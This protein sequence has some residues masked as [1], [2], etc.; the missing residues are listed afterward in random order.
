[1]Q[2]NIYYYIYKKRNPEIQHLFNNPSLLRETMEI[3]RNPAAL[4]EMMRHHDR[5][6]SN[7]EVSLHIY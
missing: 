6:L 5:A 7:L 2:F 4:Q 3:A 1:M